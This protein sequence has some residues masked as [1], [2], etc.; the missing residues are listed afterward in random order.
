MAI[1]KNIGKIKR[2]IKI[3]SFPYVEKYFSDMFFKVKLKSIESK[4]KII[5]T[6]DTLDLLF[7]KIKN[8]MRGVYM[9][10]GDGDVFLLKNKPDI[11]QNVNLSLAKE[12][13][14]AFELSGVN[15]MKC[16]AIHS[17]VYG[18]EEGMS[19]GNHKN[20]DK[21]ARQ[22]LFDTFMF[23]IGSN[24]YSP[25]AL[26]F[27]AV[28]N[29]MKANL[30]LKLLKSKTSLFIGNEFVKKETVDMLFGDCIHIKTPST[31]SYDDIDRIYLESQNTIKN[32]NSFTVVCVAMGCSGR[33]LMK[34]LYKEGSNVFLFDFGSL[35][36]GI[37][38]NATR[39]WLKINDINYQ[40]LL[41][42]L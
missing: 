27:M 32:I 4:I 2:K 28:E 20:D 15:V 18:Y 13:Q 11:L 26:H 5:S 9:R 37:E 33:P 40:E 10:F 30:F 23:F 8:N 3:K 25:V 22:L 19:T 7:F 34:R 29:V 31:N 39:T 6:E 24:I 16:L 42:D 17:E 1:K 38:G 12:M 41:R 36:D 35:L 21:L 14:E